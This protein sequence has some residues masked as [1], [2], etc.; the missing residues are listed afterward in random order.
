[1]V[2]S[3]GQE[4]IPEPSHIDGG[5]Q[6]VIGEFVD[7]RAR[8][9]KEKHRV[10]VVQIGFV[11]GIQG[12]VPLRRRPPKIVLAPT[13]FFAEG[14][15]S[16]AHQQYKPQP[17]PGMGEGRLDAQTFAAQAKEEQQKHDLGIL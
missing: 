2:P 15:E 10:L 14:I 12:G 6:E 5:Q 13:D 3:L 9:P 7:E 4:W 11:L 8:E 17:E 1:V 16:P